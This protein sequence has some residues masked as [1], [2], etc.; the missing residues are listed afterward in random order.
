MQIFLLLNQYVL[1]LSMLQLT[2]TL[3]KSRKAG[4]CAAL[5]VHL[6][7]FVLTPERFMTWLDLPSEYRYYANLLSAWLSPLQHATYTMHNFGY[8][9][10][11]KLWVSYALFG[12]LTVGMILLSLG[13][14]GRF[15]FHFSGGYADD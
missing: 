8:D 11:P 6:I 15:S 4:V 1:L 9:L 14:M 7:G 2:F 12:G 13:T 5:A 10:L 3:L